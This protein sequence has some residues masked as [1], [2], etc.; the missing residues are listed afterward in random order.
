M[1][2]IKYIEEMFIKNSIEKSRESSITVNGN[3]SA[4]GNGNTIIHTQKVI[5]KKEY[6]INPG[7]E[8]ITNEQAAKIQELVRN[9]AEMEQL[10]KKNPKTMQAIWIAL[11]RYC[12]VP[13][14]RAI[15]YTDYEKAVKYLRSWGGRLNSTATARKKDPNWRNKKYACI[16]AICHNPDFDE[17]RLAYMD[18]K[19]GTQHLSHLTDEDL[20]T[21]YRY[22]AGLNRKK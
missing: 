11:N 20:E 13:K 5:E 16:R 9:V 4:I 22:V 14:Y 10:T 21:V 15:K 7:E 19:F 2:N 12:G 1:A 17:K 6:I 18:K 8:H 3:V